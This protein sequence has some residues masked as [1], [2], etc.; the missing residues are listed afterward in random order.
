MRTDEGIDASLATARTPI[1]VGENPPDEVSI[2][3]VSSS[4][5]RITE[6]PVDGHHAR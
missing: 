1:L 3:L 5:M 4:E 6:C 2:Q